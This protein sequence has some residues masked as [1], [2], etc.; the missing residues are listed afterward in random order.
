MSDKIHGFPKGPH[1]AKV[2]KHVSNIPGHASKGA[3]G[4]DREDR[5]DHGSDEATESKGY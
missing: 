5:R 4:M 2:N 3:K 1:E